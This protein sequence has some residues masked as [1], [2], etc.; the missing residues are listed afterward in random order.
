MSFK[1]IA[2]SVGVIVVIAVV[3]FAG[4]HFLTPSSAKPRTAALTPE[5]AGA[6]MVHV[7]NT[8]PPLTTQITDVVKCVKNKGKFACVV[9]ITGAQG[10][11]CAGVLFTVSKARKVIVE[12]AGAVDPKYCA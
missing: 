10:V 1:E 6:L 7:F 2:A 3:C 9:K 5:A 8:S 12:Q 11:P 4:A